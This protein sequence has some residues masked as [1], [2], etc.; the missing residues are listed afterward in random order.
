MKSAGNT[1]SSEFPLVLPVIAID[2]VTAGIDRAR[3]NHAVCVVDSHGR[4]V[5]ATTVEHTTAGLR[6]LIAFLSRHWGCEAAIER[7]DGPAAAWLHVNWHGWPNNVAY[8]PEV[9]RALQR[10]LAARIEAA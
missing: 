3:D 10:V 9:S 6:D 8:N 7:P 2:E 1:A 5:A 4:K